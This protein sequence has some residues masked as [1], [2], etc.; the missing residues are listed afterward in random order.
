MLG[1]ESWKPL[2]TALMLPPVPFLLLILIGARLM[3]RHRGWGWFLTLFSV[4]G[5][6]LGSCSGTGR[7]IEQFVLH[8]PHAITHDRIG[9]LGE[10]AARKGS[11]AIVVLGAGVEPF[12]PEYGASNLTAL[13]LER[14]RYALWLSRETEIPVAFSGGIGWG[15][16]AEGPTEA[17]VASRIAEQEF[18]RP[19]RWI[20]DQSRDTRENAIRSVPLLQRSGID[21]IV[22]VT[23]GLHM[24][25][26]ERAFTEAAAGRGVRIEVAPMSLAGRSPG[27]ASDWLPT[28]RGVTRVRYALHEAL[29]LLMGA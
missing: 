12:S 27:T 10:E 15:G 7:I 16:H 14:L 28:T 22:L 8:V 17:A 23:H 20:E 29:G 1:I 26:A 21:H 9:Q 13:S 3:F 6:W 19:L 5:L 2:V 4:A 18:G 11:V 24:P 25:R